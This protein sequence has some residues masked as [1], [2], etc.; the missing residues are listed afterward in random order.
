MPI[1]KYIFNLIDDPDPVVVTPYGGYANDHMI[2][3]QAR[4]LEDEGIKHT[5]EDSLIKNIYNSYKR[6]E[7]D[8]LHGAKV[9]VTWGQQSAM[10]ISDKEGYVYLDQPHGLDLS[11]KET[12]WIPVT[13][14]LLQKDEVIYKITSAVMK[15]SEK[16]KFGIISDLDDT[17]LHTGVASFL[18][19]RLLLNSFMKH[20]HNRMP[21]EGAHEFYNLLHKGS[22]GYETNPFFYLSNSP[23]NLY[24]YLFSFLIKF[25][26]PKGTLMLRD[27]GLKLRRKRSFLEGNKYLKIVHI[28]ETYPAIPFILIGDAAEIDADIYLKIART[29]PGRILSIYIRSVT[30]KANITRVERLIEE[31]TDI[32]VVLVKESEKA[33][34]HAREKGYVEIE[35]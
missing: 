26:F 19:W 13:Y 15:P 6:F 24:D 20:S 27:M 14:E 16:S 4:V 5:V 11:H 32:D 2:H 10:V 18:K 25:D 35:M 17:V 12:L 30:G 8:E 28:L 29:Y 3:T 1:F 23:W 9:K 31:N 7:S 33:I 21:L 34:A 22:T